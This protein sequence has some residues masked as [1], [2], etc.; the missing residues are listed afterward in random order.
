MAML[1]LGLMIVGAILTL[2]GYIWWLVE[3]FKTKVI[4]GVG[5]FILAPVMLIWLAMDFK[6]RYQ[7]AVMWLGG[8]IPLIV[9]LFIFA[10]EKALYG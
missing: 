1:G 7:P 3:M 2:A 6:E 10:T 8:L 5:G 4:W 9:G